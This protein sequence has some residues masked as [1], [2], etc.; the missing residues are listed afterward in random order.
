MHGARLCNSA[1][2]SLPWKL[3]WTYL[4][5]CANIVQ[6]VVCRPPYCCLDEISRPAVRSRNLSKST[7]A[8]DAVA[9]AVSHKHHSIICVDAGLIQFVY[10]SHSKRGHRTHSSQSISTVFFAGLMHMFRGPGS[11]NVP[12]RNSH[13]PGPKHAWYKSQ[14]IKWKQE[15]YDSKTLPLTKRFQFMKL[16]NGSRLSN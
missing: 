6:V 1:E 15:L 9:A 2:A 11:W 14:M 10:G 7:L 8:H 5:S 3:L 13:S 16:L 12:T 4:E